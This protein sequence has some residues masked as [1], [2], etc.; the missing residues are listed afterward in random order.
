MVEALAMLRLLAELLENVE[1]V[2]RAASCGPRRGQWRAR[3]ASSG[4]D[5]CP[6][7]WWARTRHA[8]RPA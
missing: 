6:P 1:H 3:A 7:E 4:H 2:D 5:D 8:G